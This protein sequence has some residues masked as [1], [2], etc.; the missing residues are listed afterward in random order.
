MP[1]LDQV[2]EQLKDAMRAKDK[3]RVTGLRNI[4]AAF[5]EALKVDGAATLSDDKAIEILRRLSKQRKESI[6]A[7]EAGGRTDLVEAEQKELALIE[8]YL[9]KVADEATTRGWVQAAIAE[10]GATGAK[11]IGRVMSALMAA[12]RAEVD[13]KLA[14]QIVRQLLPG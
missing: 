7:Y 11:D 1:I 4:R 2:S 3:D 5:I 13:G 14:N 10:T 8:S 12:H 9:P 6:E